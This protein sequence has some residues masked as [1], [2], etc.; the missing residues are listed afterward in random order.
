MRR[1]LVDSF[2]DGLGDDDLLVMP[3]PVYFGG[4]VERSVTSGDIA[5][6][7][8]GRGR[9]VL[10]LGDRAAC[11]DALLTSVRPGDRIVVMGARDDSLSEFA[12]GLVQG[13]AA[14]LP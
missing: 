4:T 5:A 10:A 3:E 12:R 2:A 6:D 8:A 11:G 1:E 9:Q 7:I 14:R 13:L